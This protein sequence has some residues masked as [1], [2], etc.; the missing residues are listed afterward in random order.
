MN[1]G[2]GETWQGERTGRRKDG[3]TY[4][5]EMTIT[6]VINEAGV[7][8]HHIAIKRNITDKKCREHSSTIWHITMR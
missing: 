6:P 5:E 4:V 3:S 2:R 8:E 1:H 7:R